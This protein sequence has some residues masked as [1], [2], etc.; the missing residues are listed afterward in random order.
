MSVI[1]LREARR[2]EANVVLA[3]MRAAFA[4]TSRYAHP[5]SALVETIDDVEAKMAEGGALLALD[6]GRAV[7]SALFST[8]SE[9]PFLSYARLSV[10][11]AARGRGIGG[12]MI[13]WLEARAR[14]L[15]VPEVRVEARSQ[16]PDNRPYYLARGYTIT[17]YSGRYGI[18]DIRTHLV[19]RLD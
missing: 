11:P 5:S 1:F 9:P 8:S 12:E 14:T 19:K 18:A 3:L 4:E 6:A 16:M 15:G 17:G 7:G 10:H 2:E 13:A